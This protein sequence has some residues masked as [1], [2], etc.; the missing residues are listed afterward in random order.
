MWRLTSQPDYFDAHYNLGNALAAQGDFSGAAEQFGEAAKLN[1]GDA[2]AQANLGTALVQL[3]RLNEAKSH[4]EAA[5]RID[6]TNQLAHDNLQQLEQ[7]T[8][9]TPH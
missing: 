7:L 3:G 9:E 4:Y 1:P 6:P 5:L 2:N 8:R